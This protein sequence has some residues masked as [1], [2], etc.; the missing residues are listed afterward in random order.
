MNKEQERKLKFAEERLS[1]A[2]LLLENGCLE[3][4]IS[5]AYYAM[6]H[7]AKALLIEKDSSPKTHAGT[8]SELGQLYREELGKDMTRDFSRIQEK[9]ERADYGEL[10]EISDKE[11]R[12]TIETASEFLSKSHEILQ[13]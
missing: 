12:K 9:R 11:T 2:K 1:S 5:R 8:A 10:T 3:D 4:A 13:N 6:F 7:S